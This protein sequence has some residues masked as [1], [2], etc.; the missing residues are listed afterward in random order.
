MYCNEA[1][2]AAVEIDLSD[3][4]CL[5]QKP[6]TLTFGISVLDDEFC[7]GI[8]KLGQRWKELESTLKETRYYTLGSMKKINV[9]GDWRHPT[10]DGFTTS[11][12]WLIYRSAYGVAENR[13]IVTASIAKRSH[14][15]HY[16]ALYVERMTDGTVTK[17]Y[18]KMC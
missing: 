16:M 17:E 1:T 13:W 4:K 3:V 2:I 14:N 12:C 18:P 6:Q 11:E 7:A 15:D 5:S 9:E 10:A 8:V